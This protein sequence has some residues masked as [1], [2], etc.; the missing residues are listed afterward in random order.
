MGKKFLLAMV[1][2]VVVFGFMVG[3]G[4]SMEVDIGPETLTMKSVTGKKPAVFPHR[5]HQD[6][7]SCIDCH[8]V[9]EQIMVIDKCELCHTETMKNEK[10][11]SLK[12]A[13]HVQCRGCHKKAKKAGQDAPVKCSACHPAKKK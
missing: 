6:M 3:S 11:N 2:S 9:R 12:K 8:H 13:G 1:M 5:I 10:L 4:I 7:V